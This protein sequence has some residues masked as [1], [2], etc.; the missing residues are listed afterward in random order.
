MKYEVANKRP[1]HYAAQQGEQVPQMHQG[2]ENSF[3]SSAFEP[4]P[5]QWHT[6]HPNKGDGACKDKFQSGPIIEILCTC[7]GEKESHMAVPQ[8]T[9]ISGSQKMWGLW[10]IFLK[11]FVPKARELTKYPSTGSQKKIPSA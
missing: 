3:I 9:V 6:G 5:E 1:V 2:L 7:L 8:V 4:K 10:I 11:I